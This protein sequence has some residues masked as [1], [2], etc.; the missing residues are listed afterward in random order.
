M[1]GMV[2][3]EKVIVLLSFPYVLSLFIGFPLQKAI[4]A[5]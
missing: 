1:A 5:A 4:F 2:I 3:R